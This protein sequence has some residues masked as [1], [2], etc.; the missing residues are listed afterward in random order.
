[1]VD[2]V[3]AS[4]YADCALA[5]GRPLSTLFVAKERIHD[6]HH[7]FLAPWRWLYALCGPRA[8]LKL[9]VAPGKC[10][11]AP[12]RADMTK[13]FIAAFGLREPG[14]HTMCEL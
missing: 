10:W 2:G 6:L 9:N 3:A 11:A 4:S 8:T 12:Q 1:M 5:D 7:A 13:T 14:R